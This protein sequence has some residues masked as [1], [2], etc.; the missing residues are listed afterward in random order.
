MSN[1]PERL[2]YLES[3]RAEMEALR[4]EV[5]R[6]REALEHMIDHAKFWHSRGKPMGMGQEE[7]RLWRVTGPESAAMRLARAALERGDE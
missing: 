6:L 7:Y 4:A 3:L 2:D 5:E 1:V